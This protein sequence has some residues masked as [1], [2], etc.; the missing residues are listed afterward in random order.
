MKIG[1]ARERS[2]ENGAGEGRR[3]MPE[4][5]AEM[6][7]NGSRDGNEP[8]WQYIPILISTT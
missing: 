4:K 1:T 5:M 7:E 3:P 8:S 6:G 2:K